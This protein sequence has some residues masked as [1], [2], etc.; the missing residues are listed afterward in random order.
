MQKKLGIIHSIKMVCIL[1]LMVWREMFDFQKMQVYWYWLLNI[2]QEDDYCV[3]RSIQKE[4]IEFIKVLRAERKRHDD[5]I[6]YIDK[7]IR[8]KT[9]NYQKFYRL[10]DKAVYPRE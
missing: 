7:C 2:L 3:I 4:A 1:D 9:G 8:T 5:P 10:Y 6:F